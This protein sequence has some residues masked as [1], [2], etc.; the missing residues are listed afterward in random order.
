MTTQR[1]ATFAPNQVT[2]IITQDSTGVAHILSGFSED[3]IVTIEQMQE[4]YTLYTG[5]DNTGTRVFNASKS[6]TLTIPLQQTSVSNDILSLLFAN[7][8]QTS[9]GLFSIQVK[10]T[11][12]RSAYFSDDAYVAVVPAAG[13]ANTM[14]TREW[15]IQ[16]FNLDSFHGGNAIVTPEDQASIEALG[17]SLDPKWQF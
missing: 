10:D 1:L 2:I 11:S 3:S 12:G 6:A 17:G 9:R 8:D 16:A 13:F 5:A 7:D 15:V 14:Q 4:K